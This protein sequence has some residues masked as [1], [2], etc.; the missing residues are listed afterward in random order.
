MTVMRVLK[1]MRRVEVE[2]DRLGELL[3]GGEGGL[4]RSRCR[5]RRLKGGQPWWEGKAIV[6]R[7]QRGG[8]DEAGGM[9]RWACLRFLLDVG[10]KRL[11]NERSPT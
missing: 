7:S 3:R 6:K 5:P 1:E 2:Q 11:V 10:R 8:R 9:G 4:D